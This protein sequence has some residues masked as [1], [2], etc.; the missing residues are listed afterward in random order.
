M[1]YSIVKNDYNESKKMS[2]ELSDLLVSKKWIEDNKNP[3]CIFVIGGDGTF[4]KAAEIFNNILDDVIFVP[5]KSGGIG[6]YTNHNRIS[7]IQ[8]IL[9]NIEKQKPIEISV[10]EANDYK[11]INEIKII[12][13]LRPLEADV[14]IDG[15]LLETFKGTGLVFS[16]SGGSTGFAKSH[17]G[18]VIIDEN[19]IFQMLEIA[20]VSNNNFRTLSAPVIF[21]RK[22]KVEVIIKKPNDV[23]IIVD[24]KK[25]KLPEN[26]LIKI[27]MGEKN[28]KLISKNSEKLTKTKIL[29]SIF[30]TNK[31]YN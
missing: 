11:V 30:T 16:T 21:S 3:N 10:L 28:I 4:L 9:N 27:Q 31:S 8:E 22:H 5:I 24:S 15:E 14:M 7:D 25:C 29:N 17:N 1:K 26:N 20:P 18:A 13:N 12:N 2:D 6:F 19:N 23:E